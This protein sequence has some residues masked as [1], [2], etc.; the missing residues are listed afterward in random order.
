VKESVKLLLHDNFLVNTV[1]GLSGANG[2]G[3]TGIDVKQDTK[4]G[5]PDSSGVESIPAAFD[6]IANGNDECGRTGRINVEVCVEERTMGGC[7][8]E[9]KVIS[10]G[11][12][13]GVI[14]AEAMAIFG[15]KE[16]L[17]G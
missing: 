14:F 7:V 16:V 1:V 17:V 15:E 6:N 13:N 4:G 5:S 11:R 3:V 9:N 2:L 8:P 12:Y 10:S